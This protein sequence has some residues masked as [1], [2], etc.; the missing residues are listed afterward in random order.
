[1]WINQ[2]DGTFKNTALLAGAA[3]AASGKAKGSMGVDAADIDN[4]GDEDLFMT[5]LT[6]EGA[7]FY[8]NDGSGVFEERGV[9]SG[10]AALTVAQTGFGTAWID[11]DN[12][13]RLDL[14]TVNGAVQTIESLARAHDPFPLHQQKRLFRNLGNGRFEDVTA[15]AGAVFALSEVGRGAA[16]GDIDNDGDIDV[17]VNNNNGP[18]RLLIN[19]VGNKKHWVG[20]RLVG[21]PVAP[22]RGTRDRLRQGSGESRR[23]EAEAEGG[24]DML[25]ARVQITLDNGTTLWRRA[26][27]DGSY[28]SANDP[29]V[30]VGLGD[31][32]VAPRV[33]VIWPDGMSETW[34]AVPVDRYTTL[35]EGTSR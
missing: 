14:L 32:S 8:M 11:F 26:R 4:D 13:G 20:L 12:D 19:N 29:R 34:S 17:V 1:L 33:R 3:L 21:S 22:K 16:F 23:S 28:A 18:A 5:E 30:L 6:G 9:Q 15:Q 10:L 31:S 24:R 25:G 2:H 27:A 35:Q 7:N